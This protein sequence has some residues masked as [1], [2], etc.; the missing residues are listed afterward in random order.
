MHSAFH[1]AVASVLIYM[2]LWFIVSLVLKRND[3]ADVAWGGGFIVAAVASLVSWGA[4]TAR[5]F[6]VVT[7]VVIW[8]LRL[9]IHIGFRNLSKETMEVLNVWAK[10]L[11]E[12]LVED[13]VRTITPLDDPQY[14]RRIAMQVHEGLKKT[15]GVKIPREF[16]L[17]DRAAIGLGSVFYRLRAEA[18]WHRMFMELVH[19]FAEADVAARQHAAIEAAGVPRD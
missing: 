13:K 5:A 1:A 4:V 8:G 19:D 9:S 17:M 7:L 18:N 3:V 14:G 6:L 2:L 15:G 12:P 16:P 10:F 11:Y